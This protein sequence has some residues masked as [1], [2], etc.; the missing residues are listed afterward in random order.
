M[1]R[2]PNEPVSEAMALYDDARHMCVSLPC[3]AHV[4]ILN[5]AMEAFELSGQD[6]IRHLRIGLRVVDGIEAD[7]FLRKGANAATLCSL[8]W[9][10]WHLGALPDIRR[11]ELP[12]LIGAS[13]FENGDWGTV[14]ETAIENF[15]CHSFSAVL[16]QRF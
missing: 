4:K 13:T 14:L 8:S 12:G 2:L 11:A 7:G 6:A 15:G 16:P 10:H 1:L 5:A 3:P 9:F